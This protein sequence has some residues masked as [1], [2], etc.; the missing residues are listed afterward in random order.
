MPIHDQQQQY[1]EEMVRL[2]AASLYIRYYRDYLGRLVT[3]VATVRGVASSASIAGWAIWQSHSFMWASIIA[4]S[5]VTDAVKD[6]FPITKQHKAAGDLAAVLEN[7]FIDAQLEWDN[8]FSGKYTNDQISTR[9]HK[10]RGLMPQ[11]EHRNFPTG[12]AIRPNLQTLAK[13][14]ATAYFRETYGV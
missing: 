12:L 14:D 6:V 7:L 13:D 4:A 11:A 5:Q 2:K 3:A 8:I 9:L 1:W 10:L